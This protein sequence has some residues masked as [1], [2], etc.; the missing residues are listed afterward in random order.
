MLQKQESKMTRKGE[1]Q[2]N[3]KVLCAQTRCYERKGMMTWLSQVKSEVNPTFNTVSSGT[4]LEPLF[5]LLTIHDISVAS[6]KT[7]MLARPRPTSGS[8]GKGYKRGDIHVPE[9]MDIAVGE[10]LSNID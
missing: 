3:F 8:M 10:F 7:L 2:G 5:R 1:L 9:S 6:D 4:T